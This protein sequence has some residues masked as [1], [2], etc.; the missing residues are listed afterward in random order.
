MRNKSRYR[1]KIEADIRWGIRQG[2]K[3]VKDL[4]YSSIGDFIDL[5]A[6]SSIVQ[7]FLSYSF[8]SAMYSF[9]FLITSSL[10][11]VTSILLGLSI[12]DL[13]INP[14]SVTSIKRKSFFLRYSRVEICKSR[15]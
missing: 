1:K 10:L 5:S 6:R 9:F 13:V 8:F 15:A 3:R 11:S 7:S 4:K 2:N 12:S 14:I